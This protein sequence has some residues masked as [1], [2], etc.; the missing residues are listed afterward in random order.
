MAAE[1]VAGED[2]AAHLAAATPRITHRITCLSVDNAQ[3]DVNLQSLEDAC[4]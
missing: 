4:M 2:Y 1:R 3:V